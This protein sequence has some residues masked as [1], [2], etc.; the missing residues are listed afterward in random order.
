MDYD[1]AK[2]L[3]LREAF[4][5]EGIP[6]CVRGNMDPGHERM[7]KIAAAV[8]VL[9]EHEDSSGPLDRRLAYALFLIALETNVQSCSW[10]TT[11]PW[12]DGG[13]NEDLCDIQMRI[14]NFF[15]GS[16]EFD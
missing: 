7:M 12:R 10:Q 9:D 2:E 14:I 5:D 11:K 4:S 15:Q 1:Q 16:L 8:E 6:V 3:I 13:F